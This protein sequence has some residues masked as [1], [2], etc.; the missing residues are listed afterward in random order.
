M[1]KIVKKKKKLRIEG[2]ISL[3]FVMSIFC[4]LASVTVLRSHNV[5]LANQEA[6]LA[7][8]NEILNNDVSNLEFEVKGLVNRERIMEIAEEGQLKKNEK[9]IVS[10]KND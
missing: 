2:L 10:V 5:V 3:I 6:K 1:V 4:Y 7:N 9:Q 8:E